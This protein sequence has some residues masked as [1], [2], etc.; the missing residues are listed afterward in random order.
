MGD[1]G[2]QGLAGVLLAHSAATA[3]TGETAAGL[4]HRSISVCTPTRG[5]LSPPSAVAML[6]AQFLYMGLLFALLRSSLPALG[7]S[8]AA[9]F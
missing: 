9:R 3:V 5:F 6:E 4:M 8:M 2:R 1:Y 7:G